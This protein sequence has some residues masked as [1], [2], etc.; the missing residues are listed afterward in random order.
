MA[1]TEGLSTSPPIETTEKTIIL[2]PL[3]EQK[4]KEFSEH[5][6]K[7]TNQT[8]AWTNN[9]TE[10]VTK[11]WETIDNR[12]VQPIASF[13]EEGTRELRQQADQGKKDATKKTENIQEN[14]HNTYKNLVLNNME[15]LI[16]QEKLPQPEAARVGNEILDIVSQ[17]RSEQIGA[18]SIT[19]STLRKIKQ[20]INQIVRKT[21]HPEIKSVAGGGDETQ[22]ILMEKRRKHSDDEISRLRREYSGLISEIVAARQPKSS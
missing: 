2:A 19:D 14:W 6:T 8:G 21:S 5:A 11:N 22:E 1:E 10:T 20:T 13:E 3:S 16:T 15:R 18:F 17:M 7:L 9:V 12:T 4:T